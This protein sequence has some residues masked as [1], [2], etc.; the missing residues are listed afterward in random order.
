MEKGPLVLDRA[1]PGVVVVTLNR[2]EAQNALDTG[3]QRLLDD[4]LTALEADPAVRCL[5]FTGAGDRAFSAGY[6]IHELACLS[7]E[8]V[9][10]AL[11]ERERWMWRYAS[12]RMPTV[13][14]VNGV[15]HGAG[16]LLACA[17]D[18]RIG[19]ERTDFR[20][21][22]GAYNGANATWNL[23]LLVGLARAKELLFTSRRIDAGTAERIGLLNGVAPSGSLLEE[24]L[25]VA[26]EIA[27]HPPEGIAEAKR[28]LHAGPGRAL[29]DRFEAENVVMRTTLRPKPMPELFARFLNRKRLT[30]PMSG[31]HPPARPRRC[32]G[33]RMS[34]RHGVVPQDSEAAQAHFIDA[35]E[36]CF[37]RY[38]VTKT[39]MED[40]ARMAGVSRPTVYRHFA[41]RDRLILAVVM[42]RARALIGKVQA[43]TR[44]Q[45]TLEDQLV[46]GLLFLVKTGRNDPFVRI[47]VS[48]E[49][50][51]LAQHI[52]GATE[53]VVDLTQEMWEP[54]LVEAA[55]RGELNPGLDFRAVARWL[56][57]VELILVGRF[58]LAAGDEEVRHMLRTF[59]APAFRP[60]AMAAG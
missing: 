44:R 20:F 17:L 16:A 58:D 27:A 12:L 3:L 26:G 24:A 57:H 21:T 32:P 31:G 49:H 52:V 25:A 23:P 1:A 30:P 10:L 8:E 4:Q 55:A 19:C 47:L 13:A 2:P 9:T 43:V 56:T 6:D 60:A 37:E 7:P 54:F 46:E 36:A 28:L 38:G 51:D 39:T 50:L 59:L 14:A 35:A 11:L 34:R 18:L 48:P 40:I 22:A 15:A 45:E 29:P 42:R 53:A 33:G 41:D 5:V